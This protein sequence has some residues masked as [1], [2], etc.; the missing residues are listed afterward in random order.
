MSPR[1]V[2]L[3]LRMPAV[4]IQFMFFAADSCWA[5]EDRSRAL[6]SLD[7]VAD[8]GKGDKVG[9]GPRYQNLLVCRRFR[10]T[11]ERGGHFPKWLP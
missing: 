8:M 1:C 6:A 9:L 5:L 7:L 11:P 4:R 2:E 3:L 10:G